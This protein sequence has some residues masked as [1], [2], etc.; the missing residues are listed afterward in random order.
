MFK[1]YVYHCII[2]SLYVHLSGR[3]IFDEEQEDWADSIS[4]ASGSKKRKKPTNVKA[5]ANGGIAQFLTKGK[6]KPQA[7]TKTL[8]LF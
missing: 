6:S 4:S 8:G 2:V 3:E 5:P 7:E 1:M